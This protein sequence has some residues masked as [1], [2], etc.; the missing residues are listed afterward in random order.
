MNERIE[1]ELALVQQRFPE[2]EYLTRAAG[3]ECLPINSPEGW[4]R[5]ETDVACSRLLRDTPGSLLTGS[6]YPPASCSKVTDQTTTPN[7]FP[8]SLPSEVRGDS[9]PGHL[10]MANGNR[11]R[12]SVRDPIC[13]TGS[14]G[15]QGGS[16]MGNDAGRVVLHLTDDDYHRVWQHLF[17][18]DSC[19]E[20]AGFLFVRHRSEGRRAYL[21]ASRL[22]SGVTRWLCGA[23]RISLRVDRRSS[24]TRH[25]A[26]PR[27][28]RVHR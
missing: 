4:N 26:R 15:S 23:Q 21:R 6:T 10:K 22:V 16:E 25:Q 20:A 7:Q 13:S 9:F 24:R 18:D 8:T 17:G 5:S 28:G 19:D 14:T 11:R 1:A 27:L 3:F 12:T 2:V